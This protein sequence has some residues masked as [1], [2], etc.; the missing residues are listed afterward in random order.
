MSKFFQ[1]E[2]NSEG[3]DEAPK[4][5]PEVDAGIQSLATRTRI[6]QGLI[7]SDDDQ[8]QRVIVTE[9]EKRYARL[10]EII[11]DIKIKIKNQDFVT[12]LDKF[13][14]LNK[15]VE[16]STKVFE[17]EGG[18]PRFY[19]RI[20]CQI[21]V[22][23]LQ[24]TAEQKK[25]L[26]VNNSKAYN[27][28]KQR[29]KKYNLTIKDK[30]DEFINN[31]V[32]TDQSDDERKK[33][34]R[35][36]KKAAGSDSEP[37][38]Q[39]KEE[40]SDSEDDD[41]YLLQ[42]ND[43]MVRRRYWLKKKLPDKKDQKNEEIQQEKVNKKVI[44]DI[45]DYDVKFDIA[46]NKEIHID[47]DADSVKK[48]LE[49]IVSSR[50]VQKN[51][52][53]NLYVCE[54]YIQH[55][56]KENLQRAVEILLITISLQIDQ[57]K[58]E[59]PLYFN[60]QSWLQIY[61]N[62][63]ILFSLH[64]DKGVKVEKLHTYSKY[65]QENSFSEFRFISTL[66]VNFQTLEVELNKAFQ[67]ID[68]YTQEYA[69]RLSDL[70]QLTH[71]SQKLLELLK[72]KNDTANVALMSFKQLEAIYYIG[73]AVIQK[74]LELQT[75]KQAA[76][77][78][79]IFG[80]G[81]ISSKIQSL[82]ENILKYG[83]KETIVKATLYWVYNLA[84]NGKYEQAHE[85]FISN[86][87]YEQVSQM[88]T[89]IQLYYNRA[90]VQLGFGAFRQGLINET[91]IHLADLLSRDK[92]LKDLLSQNYMKQV[93]GEYR[94]TVPY[95]MSINVETIE[96]VYFL[97]AM[98]LEVPN[99]NQDLF[100]DSHKIIS[101]K[102]RQ[103]CQ[104]YD[105]QTFNPQPE[106]MRDLIYAASK[107]LAKGNWTKCWDLLK[108]IQL[109]TRIPSY[110]QVQ[111]QI[112]VRVQEQALKCYLYTFK[113]A[114]S[115]ISVDHLR[116]RFQLSEQVTKTIIYKMIYYGEIKAIIDNQDQSFLIFVNDDISNQTKRLASVIIEKLN[117][118]C[119]NNEKLM[120]SKIGSF[121]IVVDK[122]S[123]DQVNKQKKKNVTK[124]KKPPNATTKRK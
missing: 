60:R 109:W 80:N 13:E 22:L 46:Q 122:E 81:D 6:I 26:G 123:V 56:I 104:Y 101:R 121:G 73:P 103:L 85:I 79:Q 75:N 28:L 87:S 124:N 53:E 102:F 66:L 21:E 3:E 10:R 82:V 40:S 105:S 29:I 47:Y 19:I 76:T 69:E 89:L 72:I 39:Q 50:G 93:E 24:F 90:L 84:L 20:M 7:D 97:A 42:S 78:L 36:E 1:E 95:H 43:P 110:E 120:D 45:I 68:Y 70:Y 65:D 63:F 67:N 83:D 49:Q 5:G 18:L 108:Q 41:K 91:H 106:N 94:Y 74:L 107:E 44:A 86:I 33:K 111:Q 23:V 32:T 17:K 16:K 77:P 34:V 55:F 27:T 118:Q 115:N 8:G 116:E 100:E 98:L 64:Q 31:P 35:A 99:I 30:I 92:V 62:T 112:K 2:S 14:E 61:Q 15:E 119:K 58:S 37:E 25:K 96:F 59:A 9:K 88:K 48:K 114:F 38:A 11:K 52:V 57:A 51:Q 54:K 12:L 71:L 113:N 117:Q 4:G